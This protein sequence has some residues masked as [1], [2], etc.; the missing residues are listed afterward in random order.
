VILLGGLGS[1]GI[2]QGT[3]AIGALVFLLPSAV[4]GVFVAGLQFFAMRS[5]PDNLLVVW[6]GANALAGFIGA[7]AIENVALGCA[8]IGIG[9]AWIESPIGWALAGAVGGA[10]TGLVLTRLRAPGG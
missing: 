9:P 7:P 6:F 10:L 2:T 4:A 3:D 1:L 8:N 5:P